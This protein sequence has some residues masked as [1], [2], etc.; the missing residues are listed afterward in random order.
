MRRREFLLAGIAVSGWTI[1]AHAQQSDRMRRIG[2]I[3]VNAETDREGQVRAKAFRDGLRERGWEEGR[4]VRIDYRWGAGSPERANALAAELVALSPDV[5]V[6]NG[7]PA[8]AALHRLTR[9][10]P[11]VF[12]VVADPVG[13]GYV[14]SLAQ[15]GGNI[16]GFSTFEPEIGGKWLE[17]MRETAPRTRRV[18]G[19]LDA[20]FK[21]FAALWQTVVRMA[22]GF[23]MEPTML[24]F[25]TG[26]DNVEAAIAA[27]AR[28][29]GGGLIVFPTAINFEHRDRIFA[30]AIRHR[31]P[32][33]YPFRA[34]ATGGGLMSYGFDSNDLFRRG[35]S[36]VDRI[37]RGE[38]PANLPVEAPTKVELIVNL[39]TANAQGLT[40]PEAIL[41]RADEVIE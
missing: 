36:H 38:S 23:G 13:A 22:P 6:S 1:A 28:E 7:S 9:N 4:N 33:I 11:V 29:P 39:K 41:A 15:P 17:L 25:R 18:A 26:S 31:L 34:Y 32:A 19:I 16:T 21:G 3:V 10:I 30:L 35:A 40:I 24:E 14:K 20:G 5:I 27:F 12:V 37:L 8:L 2:L